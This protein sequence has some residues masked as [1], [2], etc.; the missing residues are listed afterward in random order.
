MIMSL[1]KMSQSIEGREGGDPGSIFFRVSKIAPFF[2]Q[3]ECEWIISRMQI[4]PMADKDV[5]KLIRI[6]SF[7]ASFVVETIDYRGSYLSLPPCEKFFFDVSLNNEMG[8]F[9]N[10]MSACG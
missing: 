9:Y 1:A 4:I 3:I 7:R 2:H 5:D 8:N 10:S 6:C